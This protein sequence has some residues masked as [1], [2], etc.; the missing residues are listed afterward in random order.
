MA[1]ASVG[2]QSLE[3]THRNLA[4]IS[5]ESD[6]L[7]AVAFPKSTS[8]TFAL[9]LRLAQQAAQYGTAEEA[10][11]TYHMAIFSR[12]PGQPA[13]AQMVMRNL[14]DKAGVLAWS[15][16]QPVEPWQMHKLLSCMS[17]AE[18]T[19]N[20]QAHCHCVVEDRNLFED[21]VPAQR[22]IPGFRGWTT[23]SEKVAPTERWLVPC[24]F[25]INQGGR[26]NTRH[27]AKS[28]E[29]FQAE[30][31]RLGCHVCPR[32]NAEKLIKLAF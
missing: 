13:L 24:R 18:Q 4:A 5:E 16:G 31:V 30:A 28:A 19:E 22:P 23:R 2:H 29:Q 26:L 14:H 1:S 3:P 9:T 7:I 20:W 6:T 10:G 12:A 32:F 11:K 27:P 8:K 17:Q 21:F 15:A 25:V